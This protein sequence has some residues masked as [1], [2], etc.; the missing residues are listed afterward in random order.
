M[1]LH[2]MHYHREGNSIEFFLETHQKNLIIF[3]HNNDVAVKWLMNDTDKLTLGILVIALGV[4]QYSF[5]NRIIWN[6]TFWIENL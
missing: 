4:R 6:I 5:S 2:E 3:S 1:V